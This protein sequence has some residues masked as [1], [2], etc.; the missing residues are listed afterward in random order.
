M[1]AGRRNPYDF[2]AFQ[3]HRFGRID[4]FSE[5]WLQRCAAARSLKNSG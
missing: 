1:A 5:D 4:A 3:I 2:S